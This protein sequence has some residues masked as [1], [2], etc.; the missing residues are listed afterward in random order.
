MTPKKD[1]DPVALVPHETG[2]NNTRSGNQNPSRQR[3]NLLG[4]IPLPEALKIITKKG[5]DQNLERGREGA[6]PTPA[7]ATPA[8]SSRAKDI[9]GVAETAEI[10]AEAETRTGRGGM[11]TDA[12]GGLVL[13]Q[14]PETGGDRVR[15]PE[16]ED[17]DQGHGRGGVVV[18]AMNGRGPWI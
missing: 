8:V 9:L 17:R 3:Q 2:M 10:L 7:E 4:L 18:E 11:M 13:V 1:R 16:T 15:G 14:G 5:R 6:P 12:A